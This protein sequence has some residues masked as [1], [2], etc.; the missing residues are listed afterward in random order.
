M[1][2]DDLPC[3]YYRVCKLG[4]WQVARWMPKEYCWRFGND[5][6]LVAGYYDKIG[7]KVA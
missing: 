3:G 7:E 2:E 4:H 1:P 5:R 6:I